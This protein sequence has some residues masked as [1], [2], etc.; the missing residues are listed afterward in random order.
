MPNSLLA[1]KSN[2]GKLLV[3]EAKEW[4]N[5]ATLSRAAEEREKGDNVVMRFELEI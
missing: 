4:G 1:E 2:D 5:G 3:E